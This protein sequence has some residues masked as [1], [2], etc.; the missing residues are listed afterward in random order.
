ML[1]LFVCLIQ[2]CQCHVRYLILDSS[3]I[4]YNLNTSSQIINRLVCTTAA[5]RPTLL[6]GLAISIKV[7]W[8]LSMVRLLIYLKVDWFNVNG[9]YRAS[10]NYYYVL[11]LRGRFWWIHT[12]L[13]YPTL[14]ARIFGWSMKL[15]SSL[16]LAAHQSQ[17][18]NDCGCFLFT[19]HLQSGYDCHKLCFSGFGSSTLARILFFGTASL[20][21]NISSGFVGMLFSE[22]C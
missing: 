2:F 12:S 20:K 17:L 19:V 9:S 21:K 13:L 6:K 10:L 4:V 16:Q 8:F 18:A 1:C 5:V 14:G 7:Y 15:C 11:Y 22:T 3:L